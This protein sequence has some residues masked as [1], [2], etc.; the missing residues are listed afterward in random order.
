MKSHLV[1]FFLVFVACAS[2]PFEMEGEV[3]F[4]G[5]LCCHQGIEEIRD[6]NSPMMLFCVYLESG[7]I[8]KP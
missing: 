8:R 2:V 7:G 5:C 6:S 1:W 3:K 4:Q